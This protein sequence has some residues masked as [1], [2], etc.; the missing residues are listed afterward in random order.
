MF[1]KVFITRRVFD[2][3]VSF[4]KNHVQ[5]D[6]NPTDQVLAPDA[7]EEGIQDVNGVLALLTDSISPQLMDRCP[8]LKVIANF[9]V[10]FDNIDIK[11]A[12]ERG[13]LVTNTPG[14]LTETTADFAWS[15]MLATARRVVE[16]DIK[17]A[18]E[19][20]ILVTNTPGVLTETT[21]D[22]GWSL[23]LATARRVVEADR[24]V[25]AGKFDAWGPRMLL[26][27]DIY[28]KVL[29]V[30][31]LG[32][33]GQAVARRAQG[34]GMRVLFYDPYPVGD[35]VAAEL[36][37]ESVP[38]DT[39]LRKSDFVSLHVPLLESTRHLIDDEALR[40]MKTT[41]ILINTS[42]GPVV[43]ENALVRALTADV[44]AG[45]GLDVYE[46]EP[47]LVEGLMGLDNVVLAPHIAS[48]SHE[49]RLR[50]CMMAGQNLLS[51]LNGDR[52]ANLVNPEAWDTRRS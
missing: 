3:A 14:V 17:G 11:G 27:H 44:I 40:S 6:G 12:T 52:P 43:D 34:F 2:E 48:S 30:V 41:A 36:G 5:V 13:I 42:R 29:G 8:K 49:T 25:R 38:M 9:A 1:Q 33:I 31:G 7:L 16:A 18:T 26:G 15:L 4:L 45:A 35:D 23:M 47:A 46:F 21:A 50:M 32:R 22:F 39:I 37:A 20:G 51:G 10:G 28:G 19:R 24:F